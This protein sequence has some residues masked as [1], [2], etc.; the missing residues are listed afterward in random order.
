[1]KGTALFGVAAIVVLALPDT[2]NSANCRLRCGQR[3]KI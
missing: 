3:L 1:M 2:P